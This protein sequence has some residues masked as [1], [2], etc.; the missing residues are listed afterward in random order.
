MR[1]AIVLV[2]SIQMIKGKGAGVKERGKES[3]A[4]QSHVNSKQLT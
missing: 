2:Y 4:N 3:K 1:R